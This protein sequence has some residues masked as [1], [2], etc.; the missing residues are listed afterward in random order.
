MSFECLLP[1]ALQEIGAACSGELVNRVV[2]LDLVFFLDVVRCGG[3][4]LVII[5]ILWE[6][7]TKY[8]C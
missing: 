3:V 1:L 7:L 8:H 6:D 5:M 2:I 4:I